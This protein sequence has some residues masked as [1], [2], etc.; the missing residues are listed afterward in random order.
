MPWVDAGEFLVE[1]EEGEG[2][3]VVVDAELVEDDGAAV[4]FAKSFEVAMEVPLGIGGDRLS[5]EGGC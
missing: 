1:S 2:E 5:L 4:G 3:A